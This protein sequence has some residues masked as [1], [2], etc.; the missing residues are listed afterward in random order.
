[1]R[2]RERERNSA[3]VYAMKE[4]GGD[5]PEDDCVEFMRQV[6]DLLLILNTYINYFYYNYCFFHPF[7]VCSGQLRHL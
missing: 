3:R 2:V 6:F 7:L 4:G 1:M 5:L